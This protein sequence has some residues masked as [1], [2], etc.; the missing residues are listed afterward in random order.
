MAASVTPSTPITTDQIGKIQEVVGA[1]LRRSD[2]LSELTQLVLDDPKHVEGLTTDVLALLNRRIEAVSN[3]IVRKVKIDRSRAPQDVLDA[4][5]RTQHND[6][7]V[8]TDMPRGEG[9]EVEIHFFK[10]G[11]YIRDAELEKE[12]E[13]RGLESDPYAQAQVNIDD[14]SFADEH[15]NGSLW[16][17]KDGN[18][19]FLTF[20]RWRDQRVV[21]CGR[22][23]DFWQKDLWFAGRRRSASLTADKITLG[24]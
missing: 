11:R 15:P 4:T 22:A 13:L 3:M 12:F 5:G 6:K 20:R 24:N 10:L 1:A 18:R 16:K 7:K 8:V 21:S 9:E 14:P 2:L 17:D 19:Y 23:S